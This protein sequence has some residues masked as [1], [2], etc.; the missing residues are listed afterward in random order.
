MLSPSPRPSPAAPPG[1][2]CSS[3]GPEAPCK[4]E[5]ST[6]WRR[7]TNYLH[8]ISWRGHALLWFVCTYVCV[9]LSTA[10]LAYYWTH[11]PNIFG[12]HLW[13]S[14]LW[15]CTVFG[16][17][18]YNTIPYEYYKKIPHFTGTELQNEIIYI[19]M[20]TLNLTDLCGERHLDASF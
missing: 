8:Q 1:P 4:G 9:H 5:R 17:I 14:W 3:S 7:M 16:K 19:H 18:C 2:P 6:A 12:S 10:H 20:W 11:Q 13:L 15:W